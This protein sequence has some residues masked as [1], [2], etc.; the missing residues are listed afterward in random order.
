MKTVQY[1]SKYIENHAISI[2]QMTLAQTHKKVKFSVENYTKEFKGN[3]YDCPLI[4]ATT[5]DFIT[6]DSCEILL[7]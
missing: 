5:D 2:V 6:S 4:K 7:L 1:A 3:Y